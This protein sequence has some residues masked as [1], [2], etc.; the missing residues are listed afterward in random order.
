MKVK[1]DKNSYAFTDKNKVKIELPIDIPEEIG[2]TGWFIKDRM[3]ENE[4]QFKN[5]VNPSFFKE[6]PQEDISNEFIDS[7]EVFNNK[8]KKWYFLIDSDI[9]S[10]ALSIDLY[11]SWE[12][13]EIFSIE[14]TDGENLKYMYFY[15]A[16]RRIPENILTVTIITKDN[17][18]QFSRA[19]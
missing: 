12:C 6:F 17:K 2:M 8:Y 15:K 11:D 18:I 4:F 7:L 14:I 10:Q 9:I 5:I 16:I 13:C 3:I 1:I 19:L